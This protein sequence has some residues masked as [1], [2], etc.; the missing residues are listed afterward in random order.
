MIAAQSD[1]AVLL[2]RAYGTTS[3][4]FEGDAARA[5]EAELARVVRLGDGK[6]H[7]CSCAP[8][9]SKADQRDA[10]STGRKRIYGGSSR[11]RM[12][13][14]STCRAAARFQRLTPQPA[15]AR[16]RTAARF[17]STRTRA[18]LPTRQ[19]EGVRGRLCCS[20]TR[21]PRSDRHEDARSTAQPTAAPRRDYGSTAR[22]F[23]TG[24]RNIYSSLKDFDFEFEPFGFSLNKSMAYVFRRNSC[25]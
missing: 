6:P 23:R 21:P 2:S 17:I 9:F 15:T 10:L 19:R 16:P 13:P 22:I 20:C 12:R 5:S 7:R 11:C 1:H 3:L 18:A 4:A 25:Q 14:T 24:V 8:R